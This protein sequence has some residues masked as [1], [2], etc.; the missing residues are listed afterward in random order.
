M[1]I[2]KDWWNWEI[3][4]LVEL[5]DRGKKY[6]HNWPKFQDDVGIIVNMKGTSVD[7]Y[8]QQAGEYTTKV[9]ID[10]VRMYVEESRNT[11]GEIS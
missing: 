11:Q 3:G 5:N 6:F 9:P 8:W 1:Q 10:N 4:D 2:Y 7:I